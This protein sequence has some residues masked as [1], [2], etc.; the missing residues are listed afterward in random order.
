MSLGGDFLEDMRQNL[1]SKPHTQLTKTEIR[2]D[3]E[4]WGEEQ[5]CREALIQTGYSH[6]PL[7]KM[8]MRKQLESLY[9]NVVHRN[10]KIE[11][12]KAEAKLNEVIK[13]VFREKLEEKDVDTKELKEKAET[14]EY[15]TK[16]ENDY[17]DADAV[18]QKI[19]NMEDEDLKEIKCFI[20]NRT[21]A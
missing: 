14:C 4:D 1:K 8:T 20:E 21:K 10:K 2:E 5:L 16:V 6:R 19:K 18:K 13:K 12:Y 9:V 3:V 11:R 7:S 17:S 15:E